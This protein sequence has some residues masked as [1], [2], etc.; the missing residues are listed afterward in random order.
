MLWFDE[1]Y[2]E[3]L[4]RFESSIQA[5]TSASLLIVIGTSGSTNLPMQVGAIVARRGAPMVVINRDPSPFSRFAE[6]SGSGVFIEG[7]AGRHLPPIVE[8]L[9]G[10]D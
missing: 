1:C 6:S 2:D 10:G 4:F 3:A 5:A 9:V 7:E 8:R